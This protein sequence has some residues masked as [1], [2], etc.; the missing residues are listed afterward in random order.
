MK[1][2]VRLS[3]FVIS[4]FLGVQLAVLVSWAITNLT[5]PSDTSLEIVG[6]FEH[7]K[8]TPPIGLYV[9]YAGFQPAIGQE[10][11]YL[12]FIAYNGTPDPINYHGYGAD[13]PFP[14]IVAKNL[15][16]LGSFICGN[17]STS[18][19]IDPWQTAEFKL[20]AYHFDSI[21]KS[22]EIVTVGFHLRPEYFSESNVTN[23]EPFV[24]PAEFR[25]AIRKHQQELNSSE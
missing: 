25:A 13:E 21:P 24:L 11:P 6:D 3:A 14:H 4:L 22:G 7:T 20:N 2:L 9:T 12:R 19:L 18:H 1:I 23:S 5:V 16:V 10:Q 8:A 17:G 15:D